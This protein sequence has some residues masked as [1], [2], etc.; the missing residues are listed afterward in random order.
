MVGLWARVF[1]VWGFD[2]QDLGLRFFVFK[3]YCLGLSV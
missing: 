3:V 1:S 2:V